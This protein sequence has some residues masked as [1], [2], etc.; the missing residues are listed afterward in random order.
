MVDFVMSTA[1]WYVDRMEQEKSD[2]L[3]I[4]LLHEELQEFVDAEN[5]V[6]ELDALCDLVFVC[7]GAMWKMGL[8]T[9]QIRQAL[10]AICDSNHSKSAEPIDTGSKYSAEGK[11]PNYVG[12][13]ARLKEILNERL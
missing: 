2:C 10:Q 7:I 11:G 3:T 12:P 9:K 4:E 13:E 1:L 8:Q 5:D 6:E